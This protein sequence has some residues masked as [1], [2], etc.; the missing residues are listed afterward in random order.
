MSASDTQ[1]APEFESI[2]EELKYY[3]ERCEKR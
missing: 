2:Q 3:K 1:D